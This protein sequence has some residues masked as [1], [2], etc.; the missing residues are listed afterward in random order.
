MRGWLFSILCLWPGLPHAADKVLRVGFH[1]SAPWAYASEEG[2]LQGIDYDIVSRI[3]ERAGYQVEAELYSYERLIQK[4]A[5][6]QLDFA[7]PVAVA[8]VGAHI[9][10]PYFA[11]LDVAIVPASSRLQLN[12]IGDLKGLDVVAYQKATEVLG[13]EYASIVSGTG[14]LEMADRDRQFDLLFNHKVQVMVGDEKVLRHYSKR[15][16]GENAIKVF[17][18]FPFKQYPGAAWD[19]KVAED[20]NQGLAKMR[21]SGEYQQ[22]LNMDRP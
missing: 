17:S 19:K 16:Y 20:F 18:I 13:P 12:H 15:R 7:T 6:K 11:I 2:H 9:T 22:L 10:Q 14:Y 1:Y 5:D 21:A 4:F 3:F 8:V